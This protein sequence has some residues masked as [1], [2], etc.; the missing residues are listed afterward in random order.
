MSTPVL[1]ILD[2]VL[3]WPRDRFFRELRNLLKSFMWMWIIFDVDVC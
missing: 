1:R 3:V 2:P